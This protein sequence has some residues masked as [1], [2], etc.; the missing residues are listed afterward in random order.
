[1]H[2]KDDIFVKFDPVMGSFLYIG[3]RCSLGLIQFFIAVYL[4]ICLVVGSEI[5]S[6]IRSILFLEVLI[7][8]RLKFVLLYCPTH[9]MI[10]V[11]RIACIN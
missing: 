7:S 1:M 5:R 8:T 3:S 11:S 2:F 9:Q 6:V 4:E 10:H